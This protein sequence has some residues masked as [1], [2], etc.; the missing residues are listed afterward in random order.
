MMDES[1]RSAI[2]RAVE[3]GADLADVAQG[4]LAAIVRNCRKCGLPGQEAFEDA[5]RTILEH[6]EKIGADVTAAARGI[7]QGAL[8]NTKGFGRRAS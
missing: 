4:I 8:R 3:A 2:D 1:I 6:T 5:A 7:L